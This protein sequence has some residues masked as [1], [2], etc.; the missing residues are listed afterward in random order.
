MPDQRFDP[1]R[2]TGRHDGRTE[3]FWAKPTG[4][5]LAIVDNLLFLLPVGIGDEIR[6]QWN[7]TRNVLTAVTRRS[8]LTTVEIVIPIPKDEPALEILLQDIYGEL[9]R[10]YRRRGGHAEWGMGTL[11]VAAPSLDGDTL[12]LEAEA[13]ARERG[14]TGRVEGYLVQTPD[15]PIDIAFDAPP[16]DASP[17]P[18]PI[19][20]VD[21]YL[22]RP[23]LARRFV[24]LVNQG[25]IPAA[26]HL[27]D[28]LMGSL[29]AA[30]SDRRL[31]D[32]WLAGRIDVALVMGAR[33]LAVGYYPLPTYP[34][35]V[36]EHFTYEAPQW[37]RS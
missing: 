19:P 24:V 9:S 8:P 26:L 33:V 4:G 17:G 18:L 14:L 2:V 35:S 1:V 10:R 30:A 27:H 25:D 7:G 3:S 37:P 16:P 6:Y 12:I 28:V 36:F 21:Q 11:L 20:L 22:A 5:G 29:Q 15:R 34:T 23:E 13:L 31:R 32:A